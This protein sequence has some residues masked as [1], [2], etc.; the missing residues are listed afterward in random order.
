MWLVSS[1]TS[2]LVFPSFLIFFL[3]L[4]KLTEKG[5]TK[6]T[7]LGSLA[8]CKGFI[9]Y[10]HN[11]LARY[12]YPNLWSFSSRMSK[13]IQNCFGEVWHSAHS[14]TFPQDLFCV[15]MRVWGRGTRTWLWVQGSL[16]QGLR[17]PYEVPEIKPRSVAARKEPSLLP[18]LSSSPLF[19]QCM[20]KYSSYMLISVIC[21]AK[22][23]PLRH[24]CTFIPRIF[25]KIFY[26]FLL[27]TIIHWQFLPLLFSLSLWGSAIKELDL[28]GNVAMFLISLEHFCISLIFS[29]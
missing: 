22:Y 17:G 2:C 29:F 19:T 20:L 11:C 4:L 3:I 14:C 13:S 7:F 28:L 9:V 6:D 8:C 24:S 16:L 18:Y 23:V 15:H 1:W 26:K 5:C 10:P 27:V 25:L 21:D 12:K